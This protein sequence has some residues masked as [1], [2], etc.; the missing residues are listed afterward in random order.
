MKVFILYNDKR[1]ERYHP[2]MEEIERQG[3]I[4][5]EFF[6]AIEAKTPVESINA[7]FKAIIRKAKEEGLK[8][9]AIW[10]D[11]NYFANANGWLYFLNNKPKEYDI[12]IG[13]SYLIDNRIEYKSPVTKVPEYIGNHCILVHSRYYDRFL[14]VPDDVHIDV[15]QGGLGDFYLCYP[16]A[17]LQ[18]A[19]WSSNNS[20]Y[21]DYNQTLDKIHI[22]Y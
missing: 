10:E 2:L 12:F 15:A 17:A 1:H 18:R 21:A 3:V 22:Y 11:D 6:P 8:E 7:G 4:D 20:A 5:F 14:S 16:M 9:C 13:G 19:G